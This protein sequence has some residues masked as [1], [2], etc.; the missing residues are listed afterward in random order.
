MALESGRYMETIGWMSACFRWL[1]LCARPDT[2]P[3][4]VDLD[5]SNPD[6]TANLT[7]TRRYL[8]QNRVTYEV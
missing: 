5:E 4:G 3:K 6:K 7:F 8:D 1:D 2:T